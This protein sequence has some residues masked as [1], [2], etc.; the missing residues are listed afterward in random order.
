MEKELIFHIL[1]IKE[2]ANENEITMAYRSKLKQT[3]PEDNPEGFKRLRQAYEEALEFARFSKISDE[4]EIDIKNDV[5]LW[6]EQ[7]AALY[8]NLTVRYNID[9]WNV[10]LTN[11][12]CEELDTSLE[13]RE[14]MILFLMD[15]FYLPHNIWKLI[16]QTFRITE[17][18]ESLRQQFPYDFLNYMKYYV[19]NE[20]FLPYELFEYKN[21]DDRKSNGDAYIENYFNI[22]KQMDRGEIE[23][24]QQALNDLKAYDIYHP[25]EDVEQLRLFLKTGNAQK[26]LSLAEQLLNNYGNDIYICLYVGEEKWNIGEQEEAYKLWRG[27][28][29]THPKHYMA[30]YN[31]VRYLMETKDYYQARELMMDLL[32]VDPQDETV[33]SF[34]TTVNEALIQEFRE[35][36]KN[37][38]E[39]PR[40]SKE[41]L[42]L[43]L[44]WCLFQNEHCD[45]AA[46]YMKSFQPVKEQEYG[47]CNLYGRLLYHMEQYESAL[48]YLQKW[49]KLLQ[50]MKEDG[51]EK[52]KKRMSRLGSAYYL[53]GGC[54]YELKQQ[55][56]AEEHLYKAIET[57]KNPGERLR[58]LQFL[59]TTFLKTKQYEKAVDTCDRI[60]SEDG[61]YY[62]AYL[63]RQEAFYEL[64]KGQEVVDDYHKA[65]EIFPGF[66]KPYLYAAEVFSDY[67]QYKDAKNVIDRARENNVE[68]S[69]KMKLYEVKILRNLA[70]SN[71]DRKLPWKLL[72]ELEG[73]LTEE[74]CDI[75]DNSEIAFE[76]CLLCW[77]DN[78]LKKA[79]TFL[80]KAISQNPKRLQYRIVRGHIYLDM[81]EYKA[82]LKEYQTSDKN[83]RN[84]ASYFYNQGLCYEGMGDMNTAIR[85]Y[86]NALEMEDVYGDACE[87][88]SIYYW[89]RYQECC[90]KEYFDQCIEFASRQLKITE[91]CYYLTHR[92]LLYMNALEL[93]PAIC[94]FEKA[95][96]YSPN[97]WA[98]WNNLGCCYK[99]L[100]QFEKA[101]ECLEKAV[102]YMGE[103]ID[104]L[105]YSNMAD[106]YETM[107][108]YEK[109]IECYQKDLEL[110][111]DHLEF[112]EEIGDLYYYLEQY[113]EALNAYQ[114]AKNSDNYYKNIGDVWLKKGK[115]RKC[116]WFYKQPLMIMNAK[117]TLNPLASAQN[118][119]KAAKHYS[120]FGNLYLK[121]KEYKKSITFCKNALSYSED[122]YDQ[123][124]YAKDL[125]KAYYMM[126]KY[127][128][129]EKYGKAALDY[130]D[131]CQSGTLENYLAYKAFSPVRLGIIGWIYLCIG[132]KEE[133][134]SYF[135]KMSQIQRCEHCRNRKCFESFL[136]LGCF[137]ESQGDYEQA[138]QHYQKTLEITPSC[139]EASIAI[140][141][142]QKKRK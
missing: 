53:L 60:I 70:R 69:S 128:Q 31:V 63:L 22:K 8:Q 116:L 51:T 136:Y 13:A 138:L 99:Y 135:K 50:E 29:K 37:N 15:H 100:G 141:T 110:F 36:V 106:C 54:Y 105:P 115:K 9:S 5:D 71:E 124:I 17:N 132:R 140:K 19:E 137:Y 11:P 117:V 59:T 46:E 84:S 35:A 125:A 93:E 14:K 42:Q 139:I 111:P 56:K 10:L 131:N 33:I 62:P 52:T 90:A 48:P 61:Q 108:N 21:E 55:E 121:M 114:K 98:S 126:G 83:Y 102:A 113:D 43:E 101:I 97:D 45:E 34:L 6:I 92:G 87:K 112:W 2:T 24:C 7:I 77:D 78:N 96:E 127:Q 81:K 25:Y 133:A 76:K 142:I 49:L 104:L 4:E 39:D 120:D 68:F 123:F 109:A 66:Y 18:I 88:L 27:I 3:N 41:E 30:K 80:K 32:E 26:S 94:D 57:I 86:L 119:A 103:D 85:C 74:S 118:K 129:A 47:Y 38:T 122:F 67:G 64:Q 91:N 12:L 89:H 20:T 107:L 130:F 72:E 44:G 23:G 16:D 82:A 73:E 58:C 65:V 95:L 75:E 40:L 134:L 28:L 1:E 79:L